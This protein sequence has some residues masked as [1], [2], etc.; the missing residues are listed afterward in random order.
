MATAEIAE[1]G[2]VSQSASA[3]EAVNV[4]PNMRCCGECHS[5]EGESE[6]GAAGKG[7]KEQPKMEDPRAPRKIGEWFCRMGGASRK[8]EGWCRS[9]T[10][11]PH[12]RTTPAF[13]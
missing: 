2:H 6:P 8:A 4:G 10:A 3:D 13:S 11:A 12:T 9:I 1:S 7:E 5:A